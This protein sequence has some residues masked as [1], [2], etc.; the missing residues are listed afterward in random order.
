ME[1]ISG[2]QESVMQ[3]NWALGTVLPP[4]LGRG[5][6]VLPDRMDVGSRDVFISLVDVTERCIYI[7][8]T[9]P[10]QSEHCYRHESNINFEIWESP[11]WLVHPSLAPQ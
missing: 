6:N 4:S 1:N 7:L 10:V 3:V 8:P 9:I 5:L 11:G 2:G